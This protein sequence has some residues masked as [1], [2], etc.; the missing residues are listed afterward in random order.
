MTDRVESGSNI[1]FLDPNV[2][3]HLVVSYSLPNNGERGRFDGNHNSVPGL[4]WS[5][6]GCMSPLRHT[7]GEASDCYRG[8]PRS[9]DGLLPANRSRSSLTIRRK[10]AARGLMQAMRSRGRRVAAMT[11]ES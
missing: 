6:L 2:V 9:D 3:G 1:L 8:V 11:A 10:A 5:S 4:V 7:V